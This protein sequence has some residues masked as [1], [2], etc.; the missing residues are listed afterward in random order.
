MTA[1]LLILEKCQKRQ[2]T[3]LATCKTTYLSS[4]TV[5]HWL[6]AVDLFLCWCREQQVLLGH[7]C[8]YV[9][10]SRWLFKL[11]LNHSTNNPLDI[12][13]AVTFVSKFILGWN[14]NLSLDL[15]SWW[16]DVSKQQH[17]A[18]NILTDSGRRFTYD[19]CCYSP[20]YSA[21]LPV[22]DKQSC[23][24]SI[25]LVPPLVSPHWSLSLICRAATTQDTQWW[26]TQWSTTFTSSPAASS[27]PRSQLSLVRTDASS[28][29]VY[30]LHTHTHT[31]PIHWHTFMLT[32][33]FQGRLSSLFSWWIDW[34][35]F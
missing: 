10:E 34:T 20:N 7:V 13:I 3:L 27:T 22:S 16:V 21:C 24:V 15:S 9:V 17:R 23:R 5:W 26:L 33:S 19:A 2:V 1:K 32:L 35:S 4:V 25:K 29:V 14:V 11:C 6:L 28:C 18:A 8:S 30:T 31:H 12:S